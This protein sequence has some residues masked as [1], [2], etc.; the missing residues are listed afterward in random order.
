VE[1]ADLSVDPLR[2]AHRFDSLGLDGV[3]DAFGRRVD[4]LPA[5]RAEGVRLV[6]RN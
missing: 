1:K 5:P 4:L 3:V 6:V 2:A